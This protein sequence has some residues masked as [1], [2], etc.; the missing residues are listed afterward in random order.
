MKH[1]HV[2]F[3]APCGDECPTGKRCHEEL[4]PIYQGAKA[5]FVVGLCTIA[6]CIYI[7][8]EQPFAAA[9]IATLYVSFCTFGLV[10]QTVNTIEK[11]VSEIHR[12]KGIE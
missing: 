7:G 3:L 1:R 6:F 5:L 2:L 10:V 4:A 9:A 8:T 12:I 11:L